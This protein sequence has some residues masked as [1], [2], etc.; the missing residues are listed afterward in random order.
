MNEPEPA[1]RFEAIFRAHHRAVSG[2]ALRRTNPATADDV[3]ADTF[4]VCWRRL[5]DAPEDTLPWL[6]AVARRCLANRR[7]GAERA[8][9]LDRRVGAAEGSQASRDPLDIVGE[10]DAIRV[11]FAQLSETDREVLRL[12]AWEGLNDSAAARA[13]GCVRATFAVRLYRARRRL[14]AHLALLERD[15]QT[16]PAIQEAR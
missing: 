8:A 10:R 2:Y 6:Y 14:A 5:E 9:A 1:A 13:A 11:A 7:R 16:D 12:I 3:V 15:P 4:L